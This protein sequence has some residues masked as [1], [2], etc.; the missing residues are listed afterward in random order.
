MTTLREQ[1]KTSIPQVTRVIRNSFS[2]GRSSLEAERE[3][4]EF[5][6][7]QA[8]TKAL[9]VQECPVKEKHMRT[10]LIGTFQ[11]KS[12]T[13]FW[14]IVSSKV[15]LHGQ[16]I[17]CWKFLHVLHKLMREGHP[18]VLS[19]ALKHKG[20]IEDL[21][22][23]WGHLKEGYGILISSY[24]KLMVQKIELHRRNPDFP[25]NLSV[26]KE[27]LIRIGNNDAGKFY[28]LCIEF[29]DYMDEILALE[30]GV[31]SSLDMG[32]S[33]SM[34]STGQCRLA[35][36]IVCIQDSVHLYDYTV[37]V[38]FLL[39]Q[40]LPP[41]TLTGH[42]SR[43]LDQFRKLSDFYNK[44]RNLQYFKYLVQVPS[45]PDT[46]PNFMIAA[47]LSQHVTPVAV[48]PDVVDDLV[49]D[50]ASDMGASTDS[51]VPLVDERER[52]IDQLLAEIESL[53][54][55][56]TQLE[57]VRARQEGMM[58]T[59][60]DRMREERSV[61]DKLRAEII[62]NQTQIAG[63]T[64]MLQQ[65]QAVQSASAEKDDK[66]KTLED[67]FTKL[68]EVYQ[69]LREEHISL[70]RQKAEVDK[71]LSGAEITKTEA[72]KSKEIMEKKLGDVLVQ[73]SSMKEIAAASDNEQSKQIHNL[74][75]S[76]VSMSSKMTDLETEV[77]QKEE[78]ITILEKQ[79]LERE[80]ELSKMKMATSDADQNKHNLESEIL[81]LTTQ[82]KELACTNE[83]N[84]AV[85]QELKGQL[86][87][88]SQSLETASL[89]VDELQSDRNSDDRNRRQLSVRL[90]EDVKT[91]ED[92]E[93]LTS[94]GYSLVD[95]CKRLETSLEA[96]DPVEVGHLA[97]MI[98]CL[99][100]GVTNTCPDIDLGLK[101]THSCEVMVKEA[102]EM[103]DTPGATGDRLREA[104]TEVTSLGQEVLRTLGSETDLGDLVANEISAMDVAIE[105]AAKKI[106]EL[107]EASRRKDSGAKLEVNEAVLDSCTGLVKA[108]REL[109]NRSKALQ[110]EIMAE[111]GGEVSDRE[112]YKMN[113][114]W[115]EGLI[116]AAKAVGLGAKLLV[117]AADR[118]VLGSGK[119]EEIM[120]ASQEIAGST[121]QLVIASRVKAREGSDRFTELRLAS[122][123]V[124]EATGAVVAVAKSSA[125]RAED[126]DLDF[127]G[128]SAHQT[129]TLEMNIQVKLLELESKVEEERSKLARLRRQ[130][131]KTSVDG[132]VEQ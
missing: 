53:Q 71:R 130:H 86:S 36:L 95:T 42:T 108:I 80:T 92:I 24:A 27:T 16:Q 12:S 110:R 1:A 107:L 126:V 124:T 43:F 132:S 2:Q 61:Q 40:H 98:W 69:K 55:R 11:Q 64:T 5:D 70:L 8:V 88:T 117:D 23:L 101:L 125:V 77:N 103:V 7:L 30:K 84:T 54:G 82:N 68:K 89:K 127:S 100:R 39:H 3:Q 59:A 96:K 50:A 90:M 122:K 91:I 46:P 72:L 17:T 73:I 81:E 15:P 111:R 45:L 28:E 60:E 99:G 129:K 78:K 51:A 102:G 93:T 83:G 65:A 18:R 58:R 10:I 120:V 56:V 62:T 31:F 33:N 79:L 19:E 63:L 116:S 76:N 94:S 48:V 44:C 14:N 52:Y 47:E 13:T 34:T 97:S 118:V 113:S 67:K 109:V 105:E 106:E 121:A 74:Q 6:Q 49:D 123:L 37:K 57:E 85:I 131:Y 41:D 114:R 21:G 29:L 26:D 22:K 115:T 75:A 38:L 104:V 112:F 25:G 66:S 35:P 4:F 119:F 128:L 20:L 9:S 32:K 87:S